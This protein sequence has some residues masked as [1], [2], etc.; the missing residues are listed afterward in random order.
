MQLLNMFKSKR[1]TFALGFSCRYL[2]TRRH[3]PDYESV[4]PVWLFS[5]DYMPKPDM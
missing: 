4:L 2:F 5:A 3:S 1:S